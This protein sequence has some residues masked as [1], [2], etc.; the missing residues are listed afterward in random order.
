MMTPNSFTDSNDRDGTTCQQK[1][2]TAPTVI[3]L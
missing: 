1:S 3:G 2:G